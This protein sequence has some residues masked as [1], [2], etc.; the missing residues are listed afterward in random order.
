[1]TKDK[2]IYI[3]LF[4]TEATLIWNRYNAM[5]VA[6]SFV[7]VLFGA[8]IT[9]NYTIFAFFLGLFGLFLSFLWLKITNRGWAIYN[10]IFNKIKKVYY[11]EDI[12]PEKDIKSSPLKR[13]AI[14]V[15]Y[16]FMLGY[17]IE[18][19]ITFIKLV[20]GF[21]IMGNFTFDVYKIIEIFKVFINTNIATFIISL[22]ASLIA[23]LVALWIERMRMPKLLIETSESVNSD[24]T[25][26]TPNK[27]AGERWK[28]FR[29]GV[30]N[31]PFP[32]FLSWIPRQTAENCQGKVEF[33]KKKE[34]VPI[35][36]FKGRWS[37]TTE[38]PNIPHLAIV[39]LDHPDPVTI[40]VGEKEIMDI[41]VKAEKDD[42]VYGWNNESYLSCHDWRNSNY[43]LDEGEYI[44]K[45]TISNQ[46]GNSFNKKLNLAVRKKIEDTI[47]ETI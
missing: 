25:Y 9:R 16:L 37:S 12:Y 5:L 20:K 4:T 47:L 14:L 31:K 1:V 30:K 41:I 34:V 28:F 10:K 42:G 13:S 33:Y 32:K 29:V 38:I 6:N 8:N 44:I 35:F 45:V 17:T 22:I 39:K 40:P 46:N 24:N 18:I 19:I 7:G 27:H 36:A 11:L 21:E 43:K 2:D 26:P 3:S 15:I 23:V